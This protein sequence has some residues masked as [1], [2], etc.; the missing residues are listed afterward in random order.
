[1]PRLS[2]SF[3]IMFWIENYIYELQE[4]SL[5]ELEPVKRET[6]LIKPFLVIVPKFPVPKL[7]RTGSQESVIF[8]QQFF[9]THL[10][11]GLGQVQLSIRNTII[12]CRW[13]VC[14]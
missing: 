4:N 5:T 7:K 14:V 13:Q 6:K 2:N 8:F 1:M 10:K 3:E 12:D 9:N 11:L